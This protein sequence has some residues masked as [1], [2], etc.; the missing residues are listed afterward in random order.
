MRALALAAAL[1]ASGCSAVIGFHECDVDTDCKGV[2]P[3]NTPQTPPIM[4][5]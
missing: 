4:T 3:D 2:T 5:K 1:A